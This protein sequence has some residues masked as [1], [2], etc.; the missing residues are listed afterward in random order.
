MLTRLSLIVTARIRSVN[1]RLQ[2]NSD[3]L[4]YIFNISILKKTT[5]KIVFICFSVTTFCYYSKYC[6][7]YKKT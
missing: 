7:Y 4:F 2:F 5:F 3:K 1:I 6:D